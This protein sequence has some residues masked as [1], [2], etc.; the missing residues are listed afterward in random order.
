MMYVPGGWWCG[1]WDPPSLPT[2]TL[3]FL[4]SPPLPFSSSLGFLLSLI[5]I[6]SPLFSSYPS[7]LFDPKLYFVSLPP[8]P[9]LLFLPFPPF[10]PLSYCLPLPFSSSPSLMSYPYLRLLRSL[11]STPPSFLWFY[12]SPPF[13][14]SSLTSP[15][16]P[17]L[18]DTWIA[19]IWLTY[20]LAASSRA[21]Y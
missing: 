7:L 6:F 15:S 8:P 1:L 9:S 13:L 4:S 20:L 3:L 17:S 18:K 10:L 2:P 14:S 12:L 11:L 5:D 19:W 16:L 21:D